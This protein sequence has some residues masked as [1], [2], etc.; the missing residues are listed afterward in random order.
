MFFFNQV[1]IAR[2]VIDDNYMIALI[3]FFIHTSNVLI[4]T[5]SKLPFTDW[6]WLI[7][8]VGLFNIDFCMRHPVQIEWSSTGQ[9]N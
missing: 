4:F 9:A 3:L 2:H 5:S 6:I 1:H 7:L 8:H